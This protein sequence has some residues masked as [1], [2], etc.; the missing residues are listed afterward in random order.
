MRKNMGLAD[1]IYLV[2][3][4]KGVK[5]SERLLRPIV[6]QTLRQRFYNKYPTALNIETTNL[7]NLKCKM[8][9]HELITRQK[10]IMSMNL[11][12]K[13]LYDAKQF[14]IEEL[15]LNN[16]G[17]PLLDPLIFERIKLAKLFG[18][19]CGFFTN[20]YYLTHENIEKLLEVQPDFIQISFDGALKESYE[21]I[22]IG[23]NFE[24]VYKNVQNLINRKKELEL[25]KPN[26]IITCT[27]YPGIHKKEEYRLLQ[28][29]FKNADEIRLTIA[30]NRR[31]DS[32]TINRLDLR[33]YPC[34]FVLWLGVVLG[35]EVSSLVA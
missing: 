15:F 5:V 34:P 3:L 12:K 6:L 22:R 14:G 30:D 26:I 23:S 4:R 35:T 10:G 18:F 13:I 1:K 21:A 33:S 25:E 24:K 2:C 9:P 32:N 20:G 7:C 27:M 8:C 19:K 28:E 16:Y 29:M 31:R 17:E 11:Y